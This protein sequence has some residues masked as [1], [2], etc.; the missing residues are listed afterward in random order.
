VVTAVDIAVVEAIMLTTEVEDMAEFMRGEWAKVGTE[1]P[2]YQKA[3]VTEAQED[4]VHT[5]HYCT[6]ISLGRALIYHTLILC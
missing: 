1:S 4:Q 5:I 6:H 3:E 2:A